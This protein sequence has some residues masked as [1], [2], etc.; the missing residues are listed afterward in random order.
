MTER[1]TR[2]LIARLVS[3]TSLAPAK[4]IALAFPRA[5]DR[6]GSAL[7]RQARRNKRI[8][9][10]TGPSKILGF[11]P[12]AEK[13]V[14]LYRKLAGEVWRRRSSRQDRNDL[15]AWLEK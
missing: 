14:F 7:P 11:S 10:L 6:H 5:C 12:F 4:T 9:G 8:D 15:D 2:S 1:Q 3:G 13:N